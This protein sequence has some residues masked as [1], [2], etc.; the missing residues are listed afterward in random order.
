MAECSSAVVFSVTVLLKK[1]DSSRNVVRNSIRKTSTKNSWYD[2]FEEVT[3]QIDESPDI[4]SSVWNDFEK[5]A[6]ISV[7]SSQN[8]VSHSFKKKK[9]KKKIPTYLPTSKMMGRS[10]ANIQFFKDGLKSYA[11]FVQFLEQPVL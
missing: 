6:S 5:L 1:G 10:T 8:L 4:P 9:K 11:W 3:Q 7:S 2:L